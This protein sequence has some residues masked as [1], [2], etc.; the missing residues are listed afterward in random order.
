M[1][2][3]HEIAP[4]TAV[5]DVRLDFPLCRHPRHDAMVR[6]VL[7][8]CV[9][10]LLDRLPADVL[11]AVVLTGSFAR[12]EGTVMDAADGPR[13]L[14]DIEFMVILPSEVEFHLY[15]KKLIAWSRDASDALSGEIR[16]DIEFGPCDRSYLK[17]RARPSIFVHDLMEHG[18]VIW[19]PDLLDEIPRFATADIPREDALALLLNRTIEQLD[20]Y[21]RLA[22]LDG[23]A[24]WHVAYQR[25]K[26][27]LDLAGSALAF[28]GRHV[29]SYAARP[30]A[31]AQLCADTPA[32]R[33]A[34]PP[35]FQSELER[36]ARLKIAP[37]TGAD[38]LPAQF[39]TRAQ[40]EWIARQIV[41]GTGAVTSL[42]RWELEALLGTTGE[43]PRLLRRYQERQPFSRRAWEWAKV[44]LNT[45]PAPLPV[46]WPRS[47]RLFFRSTPRALLYTAGVLAYLNLARPTVRVRTIERLLFARRSALA[48]DASAQ[49]KAITGLWRWCVRNA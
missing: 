9:R 47:A 11:V 22:G 23:D 6:S 19:G 31:F 25:L 13:V 41:N 1:L 17:K 39:S 44:A 24:L 2:A 20:A 46:S 48:R 3:P 29:A 35:G 49:R 27:V 43:L 37:G 40:R 36:A 8:G 45:T 18:K 33:H 32:L 5:P 15:R 26:L 28:C 30:A 7:A 21:D 14:G 42:L 10:F 12:G 34:L 4:T 38:V 16:V